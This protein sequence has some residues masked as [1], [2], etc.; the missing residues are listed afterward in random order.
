MSSEEYYDSHA[1]LGDA[2]KTLIGAKITMLGTLKTS[3]CE[4]YFNCLWLVAS[5]ALEL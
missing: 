2:L 1:I 3:S 5:R 4:K